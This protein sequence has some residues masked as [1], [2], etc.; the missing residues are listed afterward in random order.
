MNEPPFHATPPVFLPYRA[1]RPRVHESAFV[2]PAT[3][4]IGDV[5]VGEESSIWFGTT[6]RGDV[7]PIRIGARTSI[8]DNSVVHATRGWSATHVGDDCVVGHAVVLHGCLIGS[9][10]LVGMG[11]IVMDAARIG[12]DV[13]LGAGSLVTART[14]IPSGSL[15]MGRPARV[16]RPLTDEERESIRDG[17]AHYVEK[18]REYRAM[19]AEL[20]EASASR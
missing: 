3:R 18:C 1:Y 5:E 11:C 8:Q 2:A 12:D 7:M 17:A 19:M 15:A 13:I 14:E 4:L 16:K 9:R 10:V 20:A 6:I